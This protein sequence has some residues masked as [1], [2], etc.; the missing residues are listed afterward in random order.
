MKYRIIKH[1]DKNPYYIAQYM[2]EVS[3]EWRTV[4]HPGICGFVGTMFV[5]RRDAIKALRKIAQQQMEES[6]VR[7]IEEDVL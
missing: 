3:R 1:G 6:Q 4:S 2:D 7:V 5:S